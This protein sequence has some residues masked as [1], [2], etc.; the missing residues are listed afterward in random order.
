MLRCVVCRSEEN[1]G[2]EEHVLL[3]HLLEGFPSRGV[4]VCA[5]VHV[6]VCVVCV[7]VC[8]CVVGVRVCVVCVCA[9]VCMCCVCACV[10][11]M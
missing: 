10:L 1:V 4:C 7:R 5:C 6:L 11:V 3:D 2:F 9:C 8:V